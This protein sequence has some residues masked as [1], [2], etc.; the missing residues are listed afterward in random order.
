MSAVATDIDL[1]EKIAKTFSSNDARK[2]NAL[3]VFLKLGLPSHKSEEYR[4]TPITRA[5]EKNFNFDSDHSTSALSS[6]DSFLIPGLEANL[7]VFINGRYSTQ[8][9]KTISPTAEVRI[10]SLQAA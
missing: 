5:L 9:S 4:F 3:D 10:S 2:K 8:F 1:K 7:V 6:I